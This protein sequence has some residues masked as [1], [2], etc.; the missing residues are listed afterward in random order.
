MKKTVPPKKSD[1]QKKS[2][3]S[4]TDASFATLQTYKGT[5]SVTNEAEN[6]YQNGSIREAAK[7]FFSCNFPFDDSSRVFLFCAQ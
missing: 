5:D 7:R 4:G 6:T 3:H 2:N 1:C